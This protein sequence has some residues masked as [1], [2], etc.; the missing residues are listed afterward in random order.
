MFVRPNQCLV[1]KDC[2]LAISDRFDNENIARQPRWSDN[3]NNN[4]IESSRR[5]LVS[6]SQSIWTLIVKE[7]EGDRCGAGS[8]SR[9]ISVSDSLSW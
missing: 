3:N 7:E 8:R 1:V 6:C 9:C 4:N 5:H 2:R